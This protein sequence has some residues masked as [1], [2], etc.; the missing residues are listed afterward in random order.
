M[1]L[2]RVEWIRTFVVVVGVSGFEYFWLYFVSTPS[3][4]Q[5]ARIYVDVHSEYGI[6][7]MCWRI[8][9]AFR[10]NAVCGG[11][12]IGVA[13]PYRLDQ[14]EFDKY[15]HTSGNVLISPHIMQTNE[16]MPACGSRIA[17]LTL[18]SNRCHAFWP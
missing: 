9:E 11:V 15:V 1:I 8:A 18:L 12:W 4:Q 14:L 10:I 17:E 16:F 2:F 13:H 6:A 3:Y 7:K 5:P